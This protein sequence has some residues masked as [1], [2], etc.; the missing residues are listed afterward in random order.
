MTSKETNKIAKYSMLKVCR[1]LGMKG[2]DGR[3][4]GS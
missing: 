1:N 3:E 2:K 4:D